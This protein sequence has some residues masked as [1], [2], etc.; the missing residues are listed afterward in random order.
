MSSLMGVRRCVSMEGAR[1]A[2]WCITE[3]VE[4][5]GVSGSISPT[6]EEGKSTPKSEAPPH[7]AID[8]S[9]YCTYCWWICLTLG[10]LA[11][12]RMGDK[13]VGAGGAGG[14]Q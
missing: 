10:C 12:V 8:I 4:W 2:A 9:A 7:L 11:A 1:R 6:L 5:T 13:V 14:Q 3:A